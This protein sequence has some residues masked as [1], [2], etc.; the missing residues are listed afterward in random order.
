[1]INPHHSAW[2]PGLD[3]DIPPAYQ[4]LETIFRPE[5]VSSIISDVKE[6]STLTGLSH[7]ELVAFRPERHAVHELLIRV[8]ANIVVSEGE[9]QRDL[10]RNFRVV[11][12]TIL[13]EYILSRMDE[14]K[15][16]HADLHR[17][18]FQLVQQ[19]L[20]ETLFKA[21]TPAIE[22]RGLLSFLSRKQPQHQTEHTE[23]IQEREQRALLAY[24]EKGL[25]ADDELEVAVHKSLYRVLGL[26]SGTRGYIGPDRIFLTELVCTHVCNRYG[27]RIIGSQI[28]PWIEEA[29]EAKNFTRVV[30]ADAPV[31]ISLKGASASGKSSLRSMLKHTLKGQGVASS[32]YATISPD[33]WRHFLLDYDSLG[34]AYK[35]AGR[36]TGREVIIIDG[37]LDRY[38]REKSN[39][40]QAISHLL[41]DRFRFDSFSSERIGKILRGTYVQYVDTMY[42]YFIVTPPEATV[43]RGWERGLKTGRYKS[44]ED[45]LAHSVEAYAG[46]PKIFFRWLAYEKP[47]FRYE[48]L[49]NDVPKGTYPTTIASGTQQEMNIMSASGFIDIERYRKIDI[50]AKSPQQ[51]YPAPALMSVENNIEFLDQIVKEIPTVNFIDR[52]T[53]TKYFQ[54][55]DGVCKVLDKAIFTGKLKDGET[56]KIFHAIGWN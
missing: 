51:V 6:I 10:G 17:R 36:L 38:I 31:L 41:V 24:K 40:D 26:I 27:S 50:K 20:D 37:K 52:M 46:M 5:N 13:S 30:H 35:Y 16:T 4:K 14:I 55:Q 15:Q 25:A 29:I 28:A 3:S 19:Q 45:F 7:E 47:L 49:D 2:D 44:V 18:V 42:M 1:M 32:G 22:K 9:D 56:A 39:Q 12:N 53:N 43:E 54:V 11:A 23:T 48:F 8:T 34:A 21:R 33:I